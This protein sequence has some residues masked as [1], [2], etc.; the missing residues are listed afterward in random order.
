MILL[1]SGKKII[2]NFPAGSIRWRRLVCQG[3]LPF[4]LPLSPWSPLKNTNINN[5]ALIIPILI[6]G[7]IYEDALL[8]FYIH[9]TIRT[10]LSSSST[11]SKRSKYQKVAF[12]LFTT[13]FD[14]TTRGEKY[15][16]N[17]IQPRNMWQIFVRHFLH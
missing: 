5:L 12:S 17:F 10:I 11:S 9:S 16:N 4:T 6:V 1:L 7:L 13:G 15:K 2:D 14:C 3:I 8:V